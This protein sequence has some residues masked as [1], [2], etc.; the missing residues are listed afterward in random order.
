[1]NTRRNCFF[2]RSPAR[3]HAPR[4]A[5]NGKKRKSENAKR[6][7]PN[8]GQ[9]PGR[10]DS[11]PAPVSQLILARS[12]HIIYRRLQGALRGTRGNNPSFF[13]ELAWVWKDI[14][15]PKERRAYTDAL[16]ASTEEFRDREE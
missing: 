16:G 2:P 3:F 10:T 14:W 9:I 15:P 12:L 7:E 11:K 6:S 1:V 13:N 5:R 4:E 8:I